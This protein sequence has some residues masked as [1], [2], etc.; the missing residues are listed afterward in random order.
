VWWRSRKILFVLEWKIKLEVFVV[1]YQRQSDVG[2]GSSE[3]TVVSGKGW[4]L[5]AS[6]RSL[7]P[8]AV[9][10]AASVAIGFL[11]A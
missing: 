11:V 1:A 10:P 6:P 2:P 8:S 3:N 4:Q 5:P 7:P 9:L